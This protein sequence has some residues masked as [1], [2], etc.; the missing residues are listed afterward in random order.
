[1]RRLQLAT[2]FTVLLSLIFV[3]GIGLGGFA[4]SKALEHKAQTEIGDRAQ[5]VVQMLN[6]VSQYTNERIRPILDTG[7]D[8]NR[9]T[10]EM[11]PSF[12]A[13]QVFE[14]LKRDRAY[15]DFAYK[16]AVLNPTNPDD[17]T[18]LFEAE[19]VRRFQNDRRLKTAS[20]FRTTAGTQQ[21]YSAQPLIVEEATCLRCHSTPDVAPKRHLDR[22]GTQ[23]GYGWRLNEVIGTQIVY[24]PATEVFSTARQAL[25]LFF[26][27]FVGVFAIVLLLI[28]ALL[29]RRVIQPLKPMVQLA[30][31]L[32]QE[33]VSA[34]EIEMLEHQGLNRV[35]QRTDELGQLG[36]VFQRMGREIC[37]REQQR[38]EQLQ[39]LKVEIDQTKRKHQVSEIEQSDYFQNLKQTAQQI[40]DAFTESKQ[41]EN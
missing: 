32:T 14:T 1:M 20:G 25:F 39:R 13:R 10:P 9:L 2:Q 34:T 18:D 38:Y 27:I 16:S 40:R 23:N 22:Y 36:R 7:I 11:I 4:L 3:G 37:L 6:S 26:A 17:K 5:L 8:T 35:A 21:F 28:N 30:E 41:G 15:Q 31:K 24:L 29:K 19:L 33:T 12:S